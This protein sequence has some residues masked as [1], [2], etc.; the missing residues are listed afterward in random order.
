MIN[1][2]EIHLFRAD[3]DGYYEFSLM[4]HEIDEVGIKMGG[5]LPPLWLITE[6]KV[7]GP[8]IFDDN[9][10]YKVVKIDQTRN[11]AWLSKL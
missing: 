3:I 2:G 9:H 4:Y 5:G 10:T 11:L 7:Y 1:Y 6:K 8:N